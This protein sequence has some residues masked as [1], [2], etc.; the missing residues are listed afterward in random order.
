MNITKP[1]HLKII[2]KK[3]GGRRVRGVPIG[4][5]V[6]KALSPIAPPAAKIIKAGKSTSAM[7]SSVGKTADYAQTLKRISGG[8]DKSDKIPDFELATLDGLERKLKLVPGEW[9]EETYYFSDDV[10][11]LYC[12]YQPTQGPFIIIPSMTKEEV[13]A[14]FTLNIFS[15]QPVEIKKLEESR[16]AVIAG[17]WGDKTAGGCHLNDK[18]YEQKVDKFTWTNNPKFHMK[19]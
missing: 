8:G 19:L 3:K 14:D 9:Y 18:E 15:S 16:N 1:T 4:V 2:L 6:T 13:T 12:F 5:T 7:A 10:A 17:K 11:A